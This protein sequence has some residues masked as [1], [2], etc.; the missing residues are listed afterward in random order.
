MNSPSPAG[1]LPGRSSEPAAAPPLATGPAAPPETSAQ[2]G[3]LEVGL[4]VMVTAEGIEPKELLPRI[5]DPHPRRPLFTL[6]R[7]RVPVVLFLLTCLSTWFAGATRWMPLTYLWEC[8]GWQNQFWGDVLV[9]TPTF[10]LTFM[11]LRQVLYA[12]WFEGLV[13]MVGVQAILFSH[14]MG[15]FLYAIY[16]RVRCTLPFFIPLPIAPTGTMGAVIAMEGHKANRRQI[17]D[18]GI[19]GPIAGLCLA[20]PILWIG[21]RGLNLEAPAGGGFALDLPLAIRWLVDAVHPG[22]LGETN[23]IWLSQAN[24]WFI[25][26]WFG[27][28]MTALN[29]LPVSQP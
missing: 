3:P 18:I 14:E 21:V 12:H 24:A 19:A 20:V 29:M 13:Y 10:Q 26:G 23:H 8:L 9:P 16:Y 11:E 6:R 5:H 1:D 15:H 28:I 27:F 4:D 22:K 25:A 7:A 17:F 2:R